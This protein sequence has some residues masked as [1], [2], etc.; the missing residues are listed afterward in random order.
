MGKQKQEWGGTHQT[1]PGRGMFLNLARPKNIPS[2]A[3]STP[4][5]SASVIVKPN[6]KLDELMKDID[7]VGEKKFGKAWFED[8]NAFR[9]IE[10]GDDVIARIRAKDAEKPPSQGTIDLYAGKYVIRA[11]AGVGS[12]KEP[13]RIYLAGGSPPPQ[14]LRRIGNE[15]DL[16]AIA[17]QFYD[18][19]YIT[20]AVSPYTFYN[21]KNNWGVTLLL[22]AVKFIRDG[23]R[24]GAPDLDSV[25]SHDEDV[26]EDFYMDEVDSAMA[27]ENEA[28]I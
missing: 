2:I 12:D 6:P 25:M 24:I 23:Q 28:N 17:Q 3:N 18:G 21:S 10:S 16:D 14:M 8:S 11:N 1:Y 5:Y 13:P 22:R 9:P 26:P 19:C 7:T 4:R 15:A 27:D 20:M